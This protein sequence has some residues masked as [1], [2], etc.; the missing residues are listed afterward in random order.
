MTEPDGVNEVNDDGLKKKVEFRLNTSADAHLCV[1]LLDLTV[2]L[3]PCCLC[4][5]QLL[6]FHAGSNFIRVVTGRR[7]RGSCWR[8]SA[9]L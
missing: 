3:Q 2:L 1:L 9:F 4:C 6:L 7:G 5:F 8:V